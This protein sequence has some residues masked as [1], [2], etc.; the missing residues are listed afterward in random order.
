MGRKLSRIEIVVGVAAGLLILACTLFLI[1]DDS[2]AD[3]YAT[4]A[5]GIANSGK[6]SHAETKFVN[7]GH[8]DNLF[9]GLSYQFEVGGWVDIRGNGRK[10]S[11][12]GAYQIGV[13]TDG[14][15]FARV[16][17]GPALITT[18]DVYLGGAFQF[19]EDFFLGLRGDNRNTV[20]LLYK[21]ISSAG[22]EQ[23]NVGRDLA[24]VQVSIPF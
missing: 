14:P 15:T 12:Y 6:D 13:E 8:R 22:I 16:M 21:H 24:G 3:D 11:G 23:P 10:S 5:I 19:T 18:P 17:T 2:Y 4:A 9:L 7:A 1:V 20:G